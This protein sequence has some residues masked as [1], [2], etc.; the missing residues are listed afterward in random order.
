MPQ[1][2]GSQIAF[3]SSQNLNISASGHLLGFCPHLLSLL[4]THPLIVLWDV[5][6]LY[7]LYFV[8][9]SWFP[10]AKHIKLLFLEA[11][12]KWTAVWSCW[13]CSFE[14]EMTESGSC[15]QTEEPVGRSLGGKP[16]ERHKVPRQ[17]HVQA[18]HPSAWGQPYAVTL[19]NEVMHPLVAYGYM[20]SSHHHLSASCHLPLPSWSH[21]KWVW[22]S[23]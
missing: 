8:M 9:A 2:L 3:K 14:Q 11:L 7:Y 20:H 16:D 21:Y 13:T 22:L 17:P 15:S 10:K 4:I 18:L 1:T 23:T 6:P 19:F 12:E 5:S